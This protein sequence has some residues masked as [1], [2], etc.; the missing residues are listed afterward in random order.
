MYQQ[1]ES[2]EIRG[3]RLTNRENAIKRINKLH[4]Q[5]RSESGDD[6]WYEVR[7]EYGHNLNGHQEG[8]WSCTCKDW[9]FRRIQCKHAWIVIFSKKLRKKIVPQD[10]ILHT[11]N[12]KKCLKC[13]SEK[14]VKDGV[15]HNKKEDS[16]KYLCRECSYRFVINIGFEN[17]KKDPKL[18]CACIDLYFKGVSLRKVSDHVKQFYGVKVSDVSVLRWVRRFG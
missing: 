4:Y 2:R 3:L 12:S 5:V 18:I 1:L 13:F 6:V 9:T 16:Q 11:L 15:R 17:C 7:K 14:I 8:H 10:G